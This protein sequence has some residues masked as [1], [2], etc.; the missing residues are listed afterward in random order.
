M[1]H[2]IVAAQYVEVYLQGLVT[3]NVFLGLKTFHLQLPENG[4]R[5]S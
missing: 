5:H 2:R 1:K 4:Q 3:T